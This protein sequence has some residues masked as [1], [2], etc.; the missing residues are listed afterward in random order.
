MPIE[1]CG[2]WSDTDDGKWTDSTQRKLRYKPGDDGSFWMSYADCYGVF[3]EWEFSLMYPQ[4][5]FRSVAR[6][7]W[8]KATAGGC[9]NSGLESWLKNPQYMLEIPEPPEPGMAFSGS[10]TLTQ[11]DVRYTRATREL[12]SIGF[13]LW[14][15]MEGGRTKPY[16]SLKTKFDSGPYAPMRGV[17]I[18]LNGIT[19][20]KYVMVPTT[21]DAGE[22]CKFFITLWTSYAA[23]ITLI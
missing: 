13:E 5:W 7:E 12:F 11:E 10:L 16:T 19:P 18:S 17:T 9:V 20:G 3:E 15:P 8:T 1:W 4:D 2:D 21:Y 6:G 22:T 23:A 14:T